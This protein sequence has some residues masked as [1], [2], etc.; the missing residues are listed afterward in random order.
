MK[1]KLLLCFFTAALL[2][3]ACGQKTE[4]PAITPSDS[5]SASIDSDTDAAADND[6]TLP[7]DST[8]SKDADSTDADA[9]GNAAPLTN[10]S[11]G[12]VSFTP[13]E[14]AYSMVYGDKVLHAYFQRE[15]VLPGTGKMTIKKYSDNSV[16]E[17]I[18]LTDQS[19]CILGP[20]DS[21]FHLLG[22]NSGTHYII[23]LKDMP[24]NGELYYVNLEEGAFTSQDKTILSK[25]VS[26]NATWCYGVAA[27]GIIPALPNGADV[28]VGDVL[29]ATILI[30]EPAAYAK[31]ENYDE[32]RVR[33]NEKEFEKDGKLEIRIYQIGEDAFNVTYYDKEDNPIGSIR[34]AYN[35]S[36]PPQPEEELPQKTITNL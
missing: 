6:N 8:A 15:N 24:V 11:I 26:D 10:E 21:T 12:P 4:S 13:N 34:M 17:T 36:M 23:P 30:K 1:R 20:K 28:F 35:A 22:W 7:S 29:S 16:V 25:A 18:D 32:N 9:S 5:V 31:I 27:Y 19:R 14:K 2:L 3:S 33:F